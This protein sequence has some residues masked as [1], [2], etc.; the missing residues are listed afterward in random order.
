MNQMGMTTDQYA[1]APRNQLTTQQ[2]INAIAG[3][4]FMPSGESD[5]LAALVSQ[6]RVVRNHR[7][8]RTG[9]EAGGDR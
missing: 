6:Q 9:G 5:Q 7:C 3:T 1:Q 8:Q 4:D 2:L